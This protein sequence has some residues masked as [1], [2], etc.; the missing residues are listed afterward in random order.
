MT[1][2]V[3][4]VYVRAVVARRDVRCRRAHVCLFKAVPTNDVVAVLVE[5]VEARTCAR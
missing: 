1:V 5:D 3:D 2:L 4:E